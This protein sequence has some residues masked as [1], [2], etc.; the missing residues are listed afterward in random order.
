MTPRSRTRRSWRLRRGQDGV[1]LVEITVVLAVAV[2][3]AAS[4]LPFLR[5]WKEAVDLRSSAARVADTLLS[6]RMRSV[7]D[8][9]DCTVSVDYAADRISAAPPVAAAVIR[10][11][12]DIYPDDSDP[13]CPSLS[14]RNVVFRPNGTADAAG[15]EAV[16]LRSRSAG[17]P[18]RYRVK[19][20]GATGKVSLEKW[21]GGEWR[22]SY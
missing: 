22:G 13:D 16:Y 10:G 18:A 3:L 9:S 21:A 20:L 2:L 17:V 14:S 11:S 19:V 4:S 12:V 8:R 15:F 1:T 7:V 6:A 5:R